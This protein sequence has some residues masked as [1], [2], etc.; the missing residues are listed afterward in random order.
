MTQSADAVAGTEAPPVRFPLRRT[1]PFAEPPEYAGLRA[2]A[3]VSRAALKVNGKPAWLVTR[4]EHVR[5]VLGDSRVSSN[6]KLPGY[7]HQFHI[8]EEL[9]AQVRLMML[10]MDPP[11]HTAH[12]RMLIPE[13]TARRVRELRP[14]IQQIVDEHVDAMLAAGGPVDLVTALALPVPS[15]VICELLGVP[16]EDHARFEEWSAAL[17][18]HDLSPQEYG[19]AVQA[20]DTYLDQLVTLKEN[21][22]GD[23]L[24]SRFLEKNRTEQVAD[25]TDVVTMARLMLV[26]GHETTANMIALGV[27]ALLEHPEQMAELRADPALLPNAVEELLR[28]FSISDAG[29]ARVAVADIEVG[30]VTIRAG[31]GILAL[32]NAADHDE[33]VFPDPDTLDIHRKEARSHLAFGYGVH[34]CIGA[35]LA[36]AELEAVYGTLLRRVPGLRLAAPVEELR[37]KDDAMVYGVYELPVTW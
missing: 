10:N 7:P 35:N 27:L 24:I 15:L 2:D 22:P 17:M 3:P 23:D 30:D 1:C 14:R 36:R 34:Q 26:G 33:S 29:T 28:V 32:N 16:Y 4:H 37:F 18:N 31:E 5:Q 12:R 19:A 6:L 8:P 21:E 13:F 25:H 11:E 20:L 9:L